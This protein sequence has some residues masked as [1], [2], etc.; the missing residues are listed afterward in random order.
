MRRAGYERE[1]EGQRTSLTLSLSRRHRLLLL[2]LFLAA[3]LCTHTNSHR[4]CHWHGGGHSPFFF[5]FFLHPL[6]FNLEG[7]FFFFIFDDLAPP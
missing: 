1:R 7:F 4:V 3:M 6:T 5:L 2:L